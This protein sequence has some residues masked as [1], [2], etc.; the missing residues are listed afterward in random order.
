MKKFQV[1]H[2][3]IQQL[4]EL[5]NHGQPVSIVPKVKV[6]KSS[7]IFYYKFITW[8]STITSWYKRNVSLRSHSYQILG[9]IVGLINWISGCLF[10]DF[11]CLFFLVFSS[12]KIHTSRRWWDGNKNMSRHLKHT[13]RWYQALDTG[14][15]ER[16]GSLLELAPDDKSFQYLR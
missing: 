4:R 12:I 3:E 11:C 9:S 8:P 1:R 10:F 14:N 15:E 7:R 16:I 6:L 13:V 2:S 5:K